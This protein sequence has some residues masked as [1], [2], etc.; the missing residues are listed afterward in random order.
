MTSIRHVAIN[1]VALV[2]CGFTGTSAFYQLVN[3]YPV[4][5]ITIFEATGLFGPG[6][7]YQPDECGD[8]LL[9]NSTETMCLTPDN[10]RAFYNWLKTRPD[11]IGDV[12]GDSNLP[13]SIYGLFLID[14]FKSTMT[15]A[16]IKNIKVNLIP[17]EVSHIF[18]DK[19][20]QPHIEWKDGKIESKIE[21]DMVI[22]TTGRCPDVD[23]YPSPHKGSKALYFSSHIN[24]TSLDIIPLDAKA[25]ILGASLSAYDVVNRLFSEKTGCSFKKNQDGTLKF[26]AGT[27][28]RSVILCSRSGRLKKMKSRKTPKIRRENFTLDNF[29]ALKNDKNITLEDVAEL[30]KKDC[31]L[32]D[33]NINWSQ[34]IEP[35]EGCK[36]VD[37]VNKR[38]AEILEADINAAGLS[39][40]DNIIV[41]IFGDAAFEIWD[42]F[43]ARILP[44][45][46]EK[47]Y[48]RE[49]ETAALTYEASCPISTAEKLL[50]LHRAG[51]LS[52]LKGVQSV[53]FS[54]EDDHYLI[55][56]QFGQD[57]ADLLINTTGGVNRDVEDAQQPELIKSMVKDG[58]L[59]AYVRDG[60]KMPG[61]NVDMSDFRAKGSKNIYVA[62][63]L[64]WGPGFFT[65]GAIYMA[66]IVERILKSV[67][68]ENT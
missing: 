26:I 61:A 56:H 38:T 57:Q 50:A 35:F 60:E 16:A 3:S 45:Q 55:K 7:A 15:T 19:D 10:R 39:S 53:E 63:M 52:V 13:R 47:R 67:F 27:N 37:D 23:L 36:S 40:S 6:Y 9:N 43:A 12:K 68:D 54:V 30:I 65:S 31:G 64:L 44:T 2:G 22:L 20:G 66:I 28:E 5:E 32:N 41:D 48:R 21:A 29:L 18:E 51:K 59:S 24:Q 25:Y 17:H 42:G 62:N 8:Y 34:I 33:A 4:G 14:V 11:I 49:F 1:H 46:E 58:L